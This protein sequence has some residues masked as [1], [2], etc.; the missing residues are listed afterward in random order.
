MAT[1]PRHGAPSTELSPSEVT[2]WQLDLARAQA[3]RRTPAE[4]MRQWE[5][6]PFVAAS[7]FD[8]R[9]LHRLDA[10]AL[11]AA[12]QFD[13]L[14]LSPVAPLGVC[15]VLAPTSQDRTLSA[16]RGTEVVSDPTNVLA[17]ACAQRLLAKQTE[18]VRLCTVHQTLRAQSVA[19]APGRAQHFRLFALAQAGRGVADDG[20]ECEAVATHVQIF[21]RIFDAASGLGC[22][23][24]HRKAQVFAGPRHAVL[25]DRVSAALAQALPPLEVERADLGS[26]YYDGLRVLFGARS[27]HTG[28]FTPIADTGRFNWVARLT[29]NRKHR[30][31][32]SGMGIQLLRPLF[33]TASPAG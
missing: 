9:E 33:G 4:L 16:T 6:S 28:D 23:L 14:Q 22:T 15:S 26:E 11:E 32:A 20:F 5:R 3:G 29:A 27:P 12:P 1:F 19:S 25:A 2:P 18:N 24:L 31:V 13:A 10:I 21:D 17:V 7:E 30:F 8:Q